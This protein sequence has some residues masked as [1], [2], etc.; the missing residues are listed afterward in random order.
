[1]TCHGEIG[2]VFSPFEAMSSKSDPQFST[3]IC[4]PIESASIFRLANRRFPRRLRHVL[5]AVEEWNSG[6]MVG[7][8][9]ALED[10]FGRCKQIGMLHHGLDP[11][12]TLHD[13]TGCIYSAILI[14]RHEVELL[15]GGPDD[16]G[17]MGRSARSTSIVAR[18]ASILPRRAGKK[19]RW[20]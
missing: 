20:G 3:S 7:V 11:A 5:E 2:S 6:S 8:C 19:T 17:L 16:R 1:M 9:D 18:V 4:R 13:A 12:A 10:A 15:G 14:G